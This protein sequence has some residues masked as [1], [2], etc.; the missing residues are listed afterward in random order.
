[1][2]TN[3]IKG[4]NI[5]DYNN[6]SLVLWNKPDGTGATT[7]HLPKPKRHSTTPITQQTHEQA[8]AKKTP[9]QEEKHIEQREKTGCFK[10]EWQH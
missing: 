7:W 8:K 2:S 9:M 4:N 10:S 6:T 3:N 1:V 5:Y